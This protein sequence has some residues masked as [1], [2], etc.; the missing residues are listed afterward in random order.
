MQVAII[1][2]TGGVF[3]QGAGIETISDVFKN[4]FSSSCRMVVSAVVLL[5]HN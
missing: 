2:Q 4:S 5:F 1:Y 3:I